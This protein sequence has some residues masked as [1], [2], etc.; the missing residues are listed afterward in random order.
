MKKILATLI[1]SLGVIGFATAFAPYHP[2]ATTR[3][4]SGRVADSGTGRALP[5]VQVVVQGTTV[6]IVTDANGVFQ[7]QNVPETLSQ[8]QFKH[9][10]YFPTGVTIAATLEFEIEI[11]L[12]FDQSSTKRPGCGGLGAR[13]KRDTM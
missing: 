13:E 5:N 1:V 12:P 10:C 8:L 4:I 7:L 9:P 6:G 2:R 3:T 11:G